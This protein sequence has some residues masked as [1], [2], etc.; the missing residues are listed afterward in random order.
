MELGNIR[1]VNK[2]IDGI[3]TQA[4]PTTVNT[5]PDGFFGIERNTR[6]SSIENM[7]RTIKV[8]ARITPAISAI[9]LTPTRR[10]ESHWLFANAILPACCAMLPGMYCAI[11]DVA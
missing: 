4:H 3:A 5:Q 1:N 10:T 9:T 2:M 11:C 7:I 6:P 8:P